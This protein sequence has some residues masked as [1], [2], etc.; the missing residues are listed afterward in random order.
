MAPSH[1]T[2]LLAHGGGG[3]LS[4]QLI[5]ELLLPAF[6][7]A[8]GVL[9]DA[10]LLN[11]PGQTLAFTTDSFVVKPLFFPGGDIGRLAVFGSVNDL[12]MTGA[13]PV[14]LSLGLILEEGLAMSLL[15]RVVHSIRA[16]AEAC[17]VAV[18]TG[19]TK[20]VERGKGDGIFINTS[21]IGV[22]EHA[23]KI[24]PSAVQ[25]GDALLVSGDLGRHGVAILAAREELGFRSTLESDLAPLHTTVQE[26]INSGV[27]VHCLRDLTRG[28]LASAS[29]E[30]ARAAGCQIELEEAAIPLHP[31]V[32]GACGLLGLDPLSMA[33]EGRMLVIC[34]EAAVEPALELLQARNPQACR[35]GRVSQRLDPK[36]RGRSY[37]PVSLRNSLGVRRSLDLQRGEQL[38]RIC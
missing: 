2:V 35:V 16:A 29:D 27:E 28:G 8:D 24:H 21:A 3:R 12:A 32:S 30:I 17:G 33:N 15:E 25:P 23:L 37:H 31:S 38:P 4:Q 14:A 6:A 34:P 13:R 36:S 5:E 9:H 19:D 20:V 22:V 26:L 18:I 10:A 11:S 7:P 1:D